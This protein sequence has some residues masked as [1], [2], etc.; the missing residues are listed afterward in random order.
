MFPLRGFLGESAQNWCR[1]SRVSSSV[2][3]APGQGALFVDVFNYK[4]TTYLTSN[5]TPRV[6]CVFFF[7][8]EALICCYFIFQGTYLFA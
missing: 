5:R 8:E 3:G 2:G 6:T 7:P 4:L 1:F